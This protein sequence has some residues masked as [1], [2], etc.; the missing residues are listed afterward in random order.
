MLAD[1]DFPGNHGASGGCY[2]WRETKAGEEGLPGKTY[3]G[4]NYMDDDGE[5]E[6]RG[7]E[8]GG[9]G[10]DGEGIEEAAEEGLDER[11]GV[12]E[13]DAEGGRGGEA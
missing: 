6:G 2:G 9:G 3:D 4:T 13:V 11:V 7:E 5:E 8:G 12:D 10:A 1:M